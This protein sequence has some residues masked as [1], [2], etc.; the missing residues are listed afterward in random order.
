M[1][2]RNELEKESLRHASIH[3]LCFDHVKCLEIGY[4]AKK[5]KKK[6]LEIGA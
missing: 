6:C 1:L 4:S 3:E 5:K 2:L